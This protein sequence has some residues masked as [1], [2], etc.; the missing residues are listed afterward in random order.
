M[1]RPLF[2]IVL[3]AIV[4]GC[5]TAGAQEGLSP[6]CAPFYAKD[7]KPVMGFDRR[8]P[9]ASPK[10][11]RGKPFADA[12]FKTC[13]VRVTDH[14]ADGVRG[15]LRNDYSRRQAFN[16]DDSKVIVYALDGSWHLYDTKTLKYLGALP[17]VGGDAE[18]QWHPTNPKLLYYVPA[19]GIGMVLKEIDVTT[20]KSRVVA[21][22]GA[23]LKAIWPTANT[24]NTK[25]EGSPSRDARYWGFAVDDAQWNG[26]GMFTY[27]LTKDQIIATYDFAKNHRT[28]P[29]HVSMTPS[30]KYITISWGDGVYAFTPDFGKSVKLH[31]KSEHSDIAVDGNGDDIFVSVDY[32]EDLGA[33]FMVN[34]RTG[35]RT[36]L[37][38]TYL[39]HSVTAMHFS[40]KAYNR[41]G[42]ILMSTYAEGG[43]PWQWL[44]G[45]IFAVELKANPRI[46]DIAHHHVFH[47][48][49]FTEPH[50]SVNRDFTRVVFGSN[51][52]V[53]TK[54]DIDTYMI[55]LPKSLV[56]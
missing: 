29:D 42:W 9:V 36:N 41:P 30:G 19:F 25:S 52:D 45:K 7:W 6:R 35:V 17:G 56:R 31:H 46:I 18:P 38:P 43:G 15:F 48:D 22:L 40:G 14:D 53:K 32:E 3:A 27:D 37:F 8:Q 10:P 5:A 39:E 50:A 33:V 24:A 55:E 51:W 21:D 1:N 23:R 4:L 20:L 34:I 47:D 13:I 11:T 2:A 12:N 28:R 44:H 54:T 26:L 16:A 49:Y